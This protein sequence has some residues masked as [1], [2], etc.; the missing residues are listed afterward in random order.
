MEQ[1]TA[2]NTRLDL[3][4]AFDY[5]GRDELVHAARR[6]V[7]QG[8]APE[9][10]DEDAFR[11]HLYAPA[12]PDPD[13]VIRTSGELRVSNF[14]LWQAAY[15]EYHFTPTLWPD[16]GGDELQEALAAYAVAAA[17]VRAPVSGL[18][19]RVL[20]A[21]PLAVIAILAVVA[22]GWP[23]MALALVGGVVAMHEYCAMTREQR[24]L[25]IAG[26]AGVIAIVVV[27][28]HSGL[29]WSLLPLM[30]TLVLAF[31][32]SAVAD[33]RQSATV[34]LGV[35]L[36][37]VCWIGYGLAFLI[38]LRDMPGSQRLGPRRC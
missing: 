18:A 13:L 4:V 3:W 11:A 6:L 36:L 14:L 10:V 25:T 19:S 17:Q 31:W 32:L 9:A 26:F 27:T 23:M 12:M 34:Q 28:H 2:D 22:G 30:G 35:T 33:V 20:V 21:V 5:G 29:V 16:F 37:G 1:R 24:P 8:I 38:A 7:E 15:A